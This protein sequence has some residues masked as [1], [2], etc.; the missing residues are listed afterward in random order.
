MCP[1]T[2]HIYQSSVIKRQLFLAPSYSLLS[3]IFQAPRPSSLAQAHPLSL[4][5]GRCHLLIMLK[6]G[7]VW[8]PHSSQLEVPS[9]A[10]KAW[11]MLWFTAALMSWRFWTC[12]PLLLLQP[13]P[14]L[15]P[16]P[17]LLHSTP[18]PLGAFMVKPHWKASCA[19]HFALKGNT[20][21]ESPFGEMRERVLS[22][23]FLFCSMTA[24]QRI[25]N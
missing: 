9:F 25:P 10:Q 12:K 5:N 3:R 19:I 17:G 11:N 24:L 16:R 6:S 13:L 18:S 20:H 22:S 21:Q 4:F 8:P 23:L 7:T 15:L 1:A 2:L 14:A